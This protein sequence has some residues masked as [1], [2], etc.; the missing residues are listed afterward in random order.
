MRRKPPPKATKEEPKKRP[1]IKYQDG[2]LKISVW[3]NDGEYGKMYSAVIKRVYKQEGKDWE[4]TDNIDLKYLL[5]L[6]EGLKSVY[7]EIV[8]IKGHGMTESPLLEGG[9]GKGDGIDADESED[10]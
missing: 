4:E 7:A 8:A 10:D 9:G 6:A 5:P 2:Q 3:E 1:V